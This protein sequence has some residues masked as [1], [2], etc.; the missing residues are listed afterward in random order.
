MKLSS[1]TNLCCLIG[2]PITHSLSPTMHNAAFQAS[3]LDYCYLAFDVA[4]ASLT[5]AIEGLRALGVSGVS[6]TI[7]HKQ[8]VRNFTDELDADALLVGA[9]NCL[10]RRGPVGLAT[11]PTCAA[12][13]S[14][15]K[16]W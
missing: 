2:H 5:I 16:R 4:A 9:V 3:G 6:V 13:S 15:S 12:S 8:S 1:K 10:A 14:R 7:P 11:T